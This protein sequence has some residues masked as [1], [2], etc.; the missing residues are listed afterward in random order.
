MSDLGRLVHMSMSGKYAEGSLMRVKMARSK[1]KQ[2][3]FLPVILPTLGF[4]GLNWMRAF[5]V[6]RRQLG[7]SDIPTLRAVRRT[8]TRVVVITPTQSFWGTI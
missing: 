4:M 8:L 3:T 5:I 2:C 6:T 1:E 7:L